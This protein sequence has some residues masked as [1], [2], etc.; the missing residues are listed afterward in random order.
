MY[1]LIMAHYEFDKFTFNLSILLQLLPEE[2]LY[3][4]LFN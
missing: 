4:H 3:H 2:F 1:F